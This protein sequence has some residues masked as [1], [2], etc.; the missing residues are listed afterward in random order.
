MSLI[1]VCKKVTQVVEDVFSTTFIVSMLNAVYWDFH[2]AAIIVS[3][4]LLCA[5]MVVSINDKQ[6]KAV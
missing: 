2:I 5:D 6:E 1:N 4:L 3:F